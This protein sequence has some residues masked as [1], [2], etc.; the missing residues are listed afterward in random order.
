MGE[1]HHVGLGE[2]V[3]AARPWQFFD[4]HPAGS[5]IDPAHAVKQQDH[6]TPERHE[7]ETAQAKM[8]IAGGG[9]MTARAH[10]L[11][12][13]ARSHVNLDDAAL[14]AQPPLPVGEAWKVMAVV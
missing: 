13:A 1:K 14:R 10:R 12:A 3:F 9:L 7:F 4:P 8:I 2:G 6:E 11:C 5:A